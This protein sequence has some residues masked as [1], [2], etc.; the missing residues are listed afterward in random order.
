MKLRCVVTLVLACACSTLA[1]RYVP[2]SE[3]VA[4]GYSETK[5]NADSYE[6]RFEANSFSSLDAASAFLLRRAAE[7]T[8]ESGRR[9]FV[10]SDRR[11]LALGE[12]RDPGMLATLRILD[13]RFADAADAVAVVRDTETAA[14]GRLSA[15]AR[16]QLQ[17]LTP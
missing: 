15:K 12:A 17:R 8:L 7:L 6:V 9:Y 11:P 10:I 5:L 1:T 3:S 16:E 2:R 14:G 4:G 13:E